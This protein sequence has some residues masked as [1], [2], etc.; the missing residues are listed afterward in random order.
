MKMASR[1]S[2]K[3]ISLALLSILLI[4]C[5]G[6]AAC[7]GGGGGGSTGDAPAGDTTTI[8]G[9]VKLSSSV[10]AKPG[11]K[12][13]AAAG[14]PLPGAIIKLYNADRPEWL[15]PVAE[16]LSDSSGNY[17]LNKL[18][19]AL[20]NG[21]AYNENAA[22]PAGNYTIIGQKHDSTV[23]PP[24]FYVKVQSIVKRFAGVVVGNNL[25][26]IDAMT[27]SPPA[28][29]SMFGLSKNPDGTYGS[30]AYP[31]ARNAAIQITFSM[32]MAR[33]SVNAMS[34]TPAPQGGGV[35]KMSPDLLSATF[36]PASS[37]DAG[38]VYT[39]KITIGA[40]SVYD[41]PLPAAVTGA[42]LS[43]VIDDIPPNVT[44]FQPATQS[45]VPVTTPLQIASNEALDMNT[46]VVS[47]NP[48]I[49]DRPA[50][51]YV[52]KTGDVAGKPYIYEIIPAGVLQLNTLYTITVSGAKDMA[53]NILTA[54]TFNFR[55]QTA[56]TPPTVVSMVPAN[57]APNVAVNA[58][59]SATFSGTMDSA[60]VNGSTFIVSNGTVTGTV[61][62]N[63]TVATFMP[64]ADL[65]Y[66]TLYTVTITT[67][68]K[69]AAGTAI[70]APH[71]FS[72]TTVPPVSSIPS[73]PA[74]VAASAGNGQTTISW[75]A[76]AG[77]TSYNV[78]WSNTAGVSVSNGTK[79]SGAANPY[80]HTELV[81]GQT[82]YYVVT[83]VNSA[84]E[85]QASSETSATPSLNP[86]PP[87]L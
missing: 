14:L 4:A 41:K 73:T 42:F 72:F 44:N 39:V 16:V 37:L 17:I 28:V 62:C 38:T 70:T 85:S 63:G 35:W 25:E 61:T 69:D 45:N 84:G 52:G 47:A 60:T 64:S 3:L 49:G 30:N 65:S 81:N 24:K 80:V 31:L 51:L 22:I 7:S 23:L 12:Y 54:L 82:Y 57:N 33:A 2:S 43:D 40:W 18:T 76:S 10:G 46:F 9:S 26:A 8:S 59:I 58:V 11:Q 53:G 6:I 79:I 13:A 1:N 56:L 67:G 27:T 34:I 15:H 66:N 36:Y 78:Y 5:I 29:L 83:A 50:V 75:S 32:P 19:Y 86:P 21:N 55:T 71:T 74:G 77:A 48:S 87:P 20:Q 68:V